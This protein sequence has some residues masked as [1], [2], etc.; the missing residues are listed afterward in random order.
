M[1]TKYLTQF[2]TISQPNITNKD[3]SSPYHAKLMKKKNIKGDNNGA[4]YRLFGIGIIAHT[5]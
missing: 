3:S 2:L 5:I 1:V 4:F